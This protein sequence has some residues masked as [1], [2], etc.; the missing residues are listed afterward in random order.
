MP[1]D[2]K[3]YAAQVDARAAGLFQAAPGPMRAF[4]GLAEEAAKPGALDAKIKELM[5]LA[6]AIAARCEG[7]IAYHARAAARQGASREEV[8]E[9]VAVAVQ[10]GGGPS[11]VYG[12]EALEAFDQ[13]AG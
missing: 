4:R 9:T 11:V 5:S 1:K 2:Y 3:A 6:V 7:C 12:G 13:L 8:A 10:M